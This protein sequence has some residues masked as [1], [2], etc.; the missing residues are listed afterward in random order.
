MQL[1]KILVG[2]DVDEAG[3]LTFGSRA[4]VRRAFWLASQTGAGLDFLHSTWVD[5]D[6]LF[7]P[8]AGER[9][10]QL[11]GTLSELCEQCAAPGVA[12]GLEVTD[13]RPWL[14]MTLRVVDGRNDLVVV[15]KRNQSRWSDRRMGSV[16]MRL[17]RNCPGPVWV[18]RP[19]HSL[20]HRCVLAATDLSAVGDDAVAWGGFVARA[21]ESELYVAHAW[22][23]SMALQLSASRMSPDEVRAERSKLSAAAK[24]HIQALPDFA[25][26]G[27]RAHALVA[28]DAPSRFI[29]EAAREKDPDL[30][31]LGTVSRA[32]VPGLLIGNTAERLIYRLDASLLTVKPKDFVSPVSRK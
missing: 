10:G 6:G 26:L 13:Q 27:D 4:A 5:D 18:V 1:K 29:V 8:D 17:V 21:D 14:E 9:V 30:V 22:Q 15:A 32:G 31:V 11:E 12:W 25:A 3:V 28:C 20:R 23:M 7:E 2:V 19:D 24:E 16:S